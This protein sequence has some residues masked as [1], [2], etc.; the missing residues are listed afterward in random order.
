M[1]ALEVNVR[2]ID[3]YVAGAKGANLI[4][5][6]LVGSAVAVPNLHVSGLIKHTSRK[7]EHVIW[8]EER[9]G[10]NESV[11]TIITDRDDFTTPKNRSFSDP[12]KIMEK[13]AALNNEMEDK[14]IPPTPPII[15]DRLYFEVQINDDEN[16]DAPLLEYEQLQLNLY[17][18]KLHNSARLIVASVSALEDGESDWRTWVERELKIGERVKVTVRDASCT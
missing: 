2:D 4:D 9:I 12:T 5:E 13:I 16:L 11:T 7:S 1:R 8:V 18:H 17:W 10:L 6:T 14:P 3:R 15:F